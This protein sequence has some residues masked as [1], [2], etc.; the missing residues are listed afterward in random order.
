MVQ[1]GDVLEIPT[2]PESVQQLEVFNKGSL[3]HITL[4]LRQMI[5]FRM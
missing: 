1:E 2:Q 4:H 5:I 3:S